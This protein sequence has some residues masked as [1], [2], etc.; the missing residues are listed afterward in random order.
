ML[1]TCQD[2]T[3]ESLALPLDDTKVLTF[4]AWLLSRGLQSRT[5]STYLS[6]IRQVHLAK[7]IT[8]PSLRPELIKQLLTGAGNLDR[9][10]NDLLK[11][12][13]RLPVTVSIMR[14]LKMEK[15]H[16]NMCKERKLLLWT[17]AT[18]CFNGAFRIHELLARTKRW[19]D[20]Y[21][22]LLTRDIKLLTLKINRETVTIIQIKIKSP[23]TDRIGVDTII[24]VYESKGP[25]CPIIALKKWKQIASHLSNST[26]AFRD[27]TGRP[28]TGASF[29]NSLKLYLGK[30]IN[31]K[32][33]RIT[34]HSF[35]AG[36][37]SL[38]GTLG[39]TDE[40]IQAVGRWSSRA[41]LAYLKLPR[42]QRLT[43]AKK[44]GELNL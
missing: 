15:K 16:S 43:M 28:L 14:I 34:L 4:V 37:A 40:D 42:T 26:P 22:T 41:F 29:N 6:G 25:L 30:Y 7:G 11:K 12:P 27:E 23:K 5:I 17:V 32:T 24:D 2:E 18:L 13:K 33:S 31:Y 10:R 3:G 38:L 21:F 19:F 36:M 9:I 44:I 39:Y 35:R 20:P 8:L 1:R